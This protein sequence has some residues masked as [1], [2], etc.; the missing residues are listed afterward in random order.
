MFE[1]LYTLYTF[2]KYYCLVII[3]GPLAQSVAVVLIIVK[4]L[5]AYRYGKGAI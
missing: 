4:R 3:N 5:W 1:K 2:L